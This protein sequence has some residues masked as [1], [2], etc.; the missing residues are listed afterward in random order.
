MA[1]VDATDGTLV[2]VTGRKQPATMEDKQLFWSMTKWLQHERSWSN[3]RASNL[4]RDRFGVWPR[5]LRATPQR[6]DQAFFN[7]EKSRRIAW[8]KSKTA[9]SRRA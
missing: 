2:E 3:G 6:P 1:N 5:G 7:Y 9:E 8:A 4:Y